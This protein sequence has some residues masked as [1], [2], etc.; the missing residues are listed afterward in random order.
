MNVILYM[1]KPANPYNST[2]DNDLWNEDKT[3]DQGAQDPMPA[4]QIL[5]KDLF[6]GIGV[7]AFVHVA[8]VEPCKWDGMDEGRQNPGQELEG[9]ELQR[10][11]FAGWS[12]RVLEMWQST[13]CSP[14]RRCLDGF[15]HIKW[16]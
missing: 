2:K 11:G 15:T 10:T 9:R 6:V 12:F 4:G 1:I 8:V 3:P 13:C 7:C 14:R 16:T 5:S